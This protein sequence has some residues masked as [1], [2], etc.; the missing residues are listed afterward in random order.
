MGFS[1]VWF[2]LIF[3]SLNH[4]AFQ[5]KHPR[6]HRKAV[7][8]QKHCSQTCKMLI[9]YKFSALI[10]LC[11]PHLD[12]LTF[13]GQVLYWIRQFLFVSLRLHVRWKRC[14]RSPSLSGRDYPSNTVFE[15]L[16]YVLVSNTC[17]H[18]L[19][20]IMLTSKNISIYLTKLC[21]IPKLSIVFNYALS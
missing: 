21:I 19:K 6:E 8:Y 15:N 17:N 12:K 5:W 2:C 18:F 16:V 4:W 1:N 9:W 14:S 3:P 20:Q 10:Q 7:S 13:Y 11:S